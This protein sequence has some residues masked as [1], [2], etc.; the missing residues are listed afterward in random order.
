MCMMV[1]LLKNGILFA[2]PE[3]EA[4][5]AMPALDAG[6]IE[7]ACALDQGQLAGWAAQ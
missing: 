3:A 1:L 4:T 2:P 5:E 7:G 6:D